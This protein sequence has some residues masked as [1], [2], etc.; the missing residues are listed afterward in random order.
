M[1]LTGKEVAQS[2]K[3]RIKQEMAALNAQGVSPKLIV[4]RLGENPDDVSY[5][6]SILKN[7][8]ALGIAA[9]SRTYP[10]DLP[11]KELETAL[12]QVSNDPAIHG[13][14][15][16]CPLPKHLSQEAALRHLAPKKD[17]DGLTGENQRKVYAG[18]KNGFAPCTPSAV[19][20]LL[21]HYK[22]PLAGKNVLIVGR[23][24]VVGKPLAMLMLSQNATVTVAHSKS[25]DLPALCRRADILCAAV[26]RARMVDNNYVAPGQIVVDVGINPDPRHPAAICGDVDEKAVSGIVAALTPVPRGIGSVTTAILL[27]HVLY[28]AQRANQ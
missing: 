26:G 23:S 24:L 17:I 5:E 6:Q 11:Q 22:I 28:A 18:D 1:I 16:F 3:E 19:M 13:V 2:I 15:L 9:E 7:A 8:A 20:A 27:R 21:A 12:D 4:L 14:L 10:A 25:A